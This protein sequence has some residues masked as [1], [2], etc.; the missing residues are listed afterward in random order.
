MGG[1]ASQY[2]YDGAGN[3]KSAATSAATKRFVLDTN[4]SL[5][6]VL[7]ETDSGG[8][9]TAY[10]IYGRGLISRISASGTPL[11]YHFDVRGSTVALS[12]STGTL[13]DAYAYDPFGKVANSQGTTANPFK[14][15]G[16]YGVMDE[17][18]GLD[19]IRARYYSPDVGRFITKD[20]FPGTDGDSQSLHR[21]VYAVN[22]PIRF[23]DTSGFS[24]QELSTL[25]RKLSTTDSSQFHNALISP[26]TRGYTNLAPKA[27]PPADLFDSETLLTGLGG[28]ASIYEGGVLTIVGVLE[29]A[30]FV[31]LAVA[32]SASGILPAVYFG[33]LATPGLT[34][35]AVGLAKI[36]KGIGDLYTTYTRQPNPIENTPVDYISEV[37]PPQ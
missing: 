29:A 28:A 5:S 22:N 8:T 4:G 6:H 16:K 14:Y 7:A 10:Y 37:E 13:T 1:A 35:S 21:Y 32:G 30:P 9:V 11:Y 18:N 36:T 2:Q 34:T 31:S 17:G 3:R 24:K 25:E 15:V 27:M 23:V 33:L 20:P 19:Y 26:A 12:D